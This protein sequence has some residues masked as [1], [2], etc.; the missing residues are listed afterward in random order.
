MSFLA[1]LNIQIGPRKKPDCP[2][3]IGWDN[4]STF[5]SICGCYMK[6]ILL[7]PLQCEGQNPVYAKVRK[8]S[9]TKRIIIFFPHFCQS[10]TS[11]KPCWNVM[12]P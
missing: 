5:I 2:F 9:K 4:N 10:E 11:L 7:I 1:T 3:N 12:L 8:I 6:K